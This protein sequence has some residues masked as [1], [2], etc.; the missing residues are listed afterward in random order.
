VNEKKSP[1]RNGVVFRRDEEAEKILEA[2][3]LQRLSPFEI[4]GFSTFRIAD[5]CDEAKRSYVNGCFRSCIICSSTAVELGLKHAMIFLSEDWEQTYW[6]IEVG[7]LRFY[8]IVERLGKMNRKLSGLLADAIWLRKARNEIVAHPIYIGNPFVM[9]KPGYLEFEEPELQIWA[10][11]IMLR[12]ISKLLWFVEPDKRKEIEEKK[13]TKK[14]DQ[15]RILEEFSVMDYIK[16]R[17]PVRYEPADFL[18]WR[19]IQNELIGEI[20]FSSIQKNGEYNEYP[21]SNNCLMN[22][23]RVLLF[24]K[25]TV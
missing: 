3:R 1:L 8:K 14:G 11:K 24:S 9:K 2:S 20:A 15:G 12:D 25:S 23:V 16:Q 21:S 13:F 19:V 10:S 22:C 18:R 4:S 7:K 17:K 5:Y 6:E